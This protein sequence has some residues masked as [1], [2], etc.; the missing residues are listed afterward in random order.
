V[1]VLLVDL[2]GTDGGPTTESI[3][4]DLGCDVD[5]R[6]FVPPIEAEALPPARPDVLLVDSGPRPELGASEL[7]RLRQMPLLADVPALLAIP[8]DQVMRVDFSS[9]FADFVLTP[10]VPHELYVRLRQI[11]WHASA[12]SGEEM[13]KCDDL[14]VDLPG[15]EVTVSGRRIALTRQEF[16]LLAYLLRHR[17]KVHARERL[18]RSVW[19]VRRSIVTRTV[20]IH[21]RRLREK[22]GSAG[23]LIETVRGVGYKIGGP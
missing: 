23:R 14:W 5:H 21:V 10:W 16:D 4:R 11:E 12:F 6:G 17:G 15:R 7:R 8:A 3:L 18:L 20:D 22:L 2:G 19:G 1:R 9:G 13:L